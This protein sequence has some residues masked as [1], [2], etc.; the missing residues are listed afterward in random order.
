MIKKQPVVP[1][2]IMLVVSIVQVKNATAQ[3][4]IKR[5]TIEITSTFKPVLRDAV[6]INFNAAP[7]AVDSSKPTLKY[8]L[9]IQ[10]LSFNY[11]PI[12]IKPVP[13]DADSGAAWKY[14]NY[15]K[16]GAGNVHL[17]FLQS[18]FSFGDG[19][20]TFFNVFA[21]HLSS[22]GSMPFQKNSQTSASAAATYKTQKNLEWNAALGFKSDDYFFYG[23][24]P[25]TL[26]FNKEDLRQRFQTFDGKVSLR[27]TEP[28]T[29]GLNYNPSFKTSVF[30]GKNEFRR[31]TESNTVLNLP[32]QKSIG[33]IF[34][35]KL[36]LTADLTSYRPVNKTKVQ[37][38]LYYFSPSLLLKTPNLYLE[39]GLIPSWDNGMFA[40]LPN[41]MADITTN[42]KRFTL[43]LGW[44]GYYNKG[45]YERFASVNPWIMQ[46][47]QL[48]NT[49][50]QERY[51]GFKG[52]VLN[53]F[54]YSA[55]AGFVSYRNM[56]L[57][58]NDSIDGKTFLT[59]YSSSMQAIQF[60]GEIGY[61]QG[62]TFTATANL[63]WNQYSKVTDQT[64]AWGLLPL[65]FIVNM[66]WQ[67]VHN[68]WLKS[69]LFAWDGA[70]YQTSKKEARKG[71][72]AFD[73]NA[74]LEFKITK[75]F[76]LWVQMNNIFNNRYERW[77]QY[78]VYGFNLLG[79]VVFSF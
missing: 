16:A 26:V 1:F 34:G 79:G 33:K 66:N 10:N 45:S 18:G 14:S 69:D 5:K 42:D 57:F 73:L 48:L 17:P 12:P 65:E 60:H 27:N 56:P 71:E 23:Y 37:N 53:H 41:F 47:D 52:S 25:S 44:I 78:P 32:L 59:V 58:I 64:R 7:P 30:N 13:L 77:H 28:T 40:T 38:N 74:G 21:K 4:G 62:E 29:Y 50:V 22:K 20:N 24:Q 43:Q 54:T 55:K 51:A 68:V 49:R 19:K 75:Q 67:V 72:G 46:P 2:I 8:N 39:A 11:I 61:T 70:A 15:I 76:N 9:P 31:A 63:T 6:K 36:G 35:I 3:E